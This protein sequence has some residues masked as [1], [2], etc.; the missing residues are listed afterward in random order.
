MSLRWLGLWAVV[1]VVSACTINVVVPTPTAVPPTPTPTMA[2]ASASTPTST[3]LTTY[4]A[5]RLRNA[6][7][8]PRINVFEATFGVTFE[9][10]RK[11]WRSDVALL[12]YCEGRLDT[13]RPELPQ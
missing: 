2:P 1:L 13:K 3:D 6:N 5:I 11:G 4:E 9:C 7:V 12:V 8:E 10:Q